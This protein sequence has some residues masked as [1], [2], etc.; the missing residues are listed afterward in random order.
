[1]LPTLLLV[2][3]WQEHHEGAMVITSAGQGV[4]SKQVGRKDKVSSQKI[5]PQISLRASFPYGSLHT[6]WEHIWSMC[7]LLLQV[8]EGP[9]TLEQVLV[10]KELGRGCHRRQE[11]V[12]LCFQSL[13]LLHQI[14]PATC[15]V[16]YLSVMIHVFDT[17]LELS[18]WS[19]FQTSSDFRHDWSMSLLV[20]SVSIICVCVFL[21]QI[22]FKISQNAL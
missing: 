18:S 19:V 20:F 13:Y 21:F 8:P 7:I 17:D 3:L 14:S 6:P 11:T 1:M 2:R 15:S 9:N 12:A 22:R 10:L 4:C 5:A 16:S